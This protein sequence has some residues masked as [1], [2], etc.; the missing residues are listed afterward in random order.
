MQ[1]AHD[2]ETEWTGLFGG[3]RTDFRFRLNWS[4]SSSHFYYI[5]ILY[6]SGIIS[7]SG[8]VVGEWEL[9]GAVLLGAE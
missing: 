1:R 6:N 3:E 7:L 8:V 2:I 4:F 5:S 9:G